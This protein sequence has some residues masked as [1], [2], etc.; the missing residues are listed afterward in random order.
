MTDE[1]KAGIIISLWTVI[2]GVGLL[3]GHIVG[4]L[5]SV[6]ATIIT[7]MMFYFDYRLEKKSEALKNARKAFLD[8]YYRGR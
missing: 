2:F 4:Y 6:F 1:T 3:S 5:I 7:V 8:E